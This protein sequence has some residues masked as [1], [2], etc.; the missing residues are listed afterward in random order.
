MKR[1]LLVA[2]LAVICTACSSST[3]GRDRTSSPAVASA[4]VVDPL[5]AAERWY[6]MGDGAVPI[7]AGCSAE[8]SLDCDVWSG[9]LRC[10]GNVGLVQVYGGLNSMAGMQLD[11]KGAR[12]LGRE[13]LSGAV[14]LRW[15][16]T[17][18][19]RFCADVIREQMNWELCAPDDISRRQAILAVIRGYSQSFPVGHEIACA[20]RGC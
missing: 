2:A 1:S 13:S 17:L 15:G 16:T 12:V 6:P 8:C 11:Q 14:G 19:T 3:P 4:S 7:P 20:N 9:Q 10:G 5:G 18:D